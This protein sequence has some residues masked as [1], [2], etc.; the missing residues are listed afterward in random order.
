MRF[1]KLAVISFIIFFALLTAIGMLFPPTVTV[2]RRGVIQAP[3]EKIYP[4]I[5]DLR[6]WHTWLA[7]SSVS[8]E[9][10]TFNTT[11][12]GAAIA[13]GGKKVEIIAVTNDYIE[14]LWELN[15][16]K[17]HTQVSGFYLL[18]DKETPGTVVQLHFT[19]KLKWYPWERIAARLNERVLGPVLDR[20]ILQLEKAVQA[21]TN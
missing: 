5:A 9:Q 17:K 1:I 15:K 2:V 7:D 19:Q 13:I 12:K 20:N 6:N 3:K 14:A 18:P 10:L 16:E 4:F 11:G 8:F 21:T